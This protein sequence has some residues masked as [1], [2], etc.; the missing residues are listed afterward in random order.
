MKTSNMKTA[1][2]IGATSGIGRA[3]AVSLA[4]DGWKV[5]IAGRRAERLEEL[6]AQFPEGAIVTQVLDVT[7]EESVRNLDD[8]LSRTGAPDVFLHVAGIGCQNPSIDESKELSVIETNC[9]G[10]VRI[11]AHFLNYVKSSG[12]YDDKRKVQVGVVTSVAGTA[13]LGIS[14][15]YSASKKM[16]MTYLSGLSQLARMEKIPVRFTDIRPGFVDTEI[17]DPGRKYPVLIST[18]KAARYIRKGLE[19]KRRII[20]FDWRFRLIVI[21]WKLIPRALWER[22]T[23]IRN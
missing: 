18:E 12:A 2:I 10:M 14:A 7:K 4:K 5:G 19:R 1:I 9:M 23:F 16:Q 3:L 8:L 13:G 17:L 11:V 22:L 6:A 21:L 20:T 15:A